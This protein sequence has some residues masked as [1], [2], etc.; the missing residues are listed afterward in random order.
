MVLIFSL[1]NVYFWR[2]SIFVSLI[3]E[4]ETEFKTY[5]FSCLLIYF[6]RWTTR[7]LAHRWCT[8]RCTCQCPLTILGFKCYFPNFFN[9]WVLVVRY[10]WPRSL[11]EYNCLHEPLHYLKSIL[12]G[13]GKVLITTGLR[14]WNILVLTSLVEKHQCVG[15]WCTVR[16]G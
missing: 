2:S 1:N 15:R 10:Y 5:S 13:L 9:H 12:L 6:E 3:E 7:Q 11:R 8:Y 16:L 4:H 14:L